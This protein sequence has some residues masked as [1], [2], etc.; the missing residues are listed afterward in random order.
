MQWG[1]EDTYSCSACQLLR[2]T[3]YWELAAGRSRVSSCTD[4]AASPTALKQHAECWFA[5]RTSI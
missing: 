3:W 2:R 5:M 4:P 1:D